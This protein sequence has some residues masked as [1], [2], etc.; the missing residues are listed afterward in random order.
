MLSTPPHIKALPEPIAILPAAIWID[1]IEDPH[2]LFTVIPDVL[3]SIPLKKV[4]SFPIL[5]PCSPSGKAHPTI[6]SSIS[7]GLIFVLETKFLITSASMISGLTSIRSP[8]LAMVKGER[9]YPAIT[10]LYIIIFNSW[11]NIVFDYFGNGKDVTVPF[12]FFSSKVSTKTFCP[13]FQ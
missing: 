3:I 8:F 13:S 5:K 4:T 7:I 11:H 1:S 10:D 6:T 2:H 9:E 12:L